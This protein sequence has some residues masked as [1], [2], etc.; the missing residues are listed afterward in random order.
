MMGKVLVTNKRLEEGH[1]FRQIE[2]EDDSPAF[3]RLIFLIT[4]EGAS[5]AATADAMA[6]SQQV[7]E[8]KAGEQLH[9]QRS[10]HHPEVMRNVSSSLLFTRL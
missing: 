3:T 8:L 5:E 7:Q 2:L 10:F 4:G 6:V 9:L 1:R